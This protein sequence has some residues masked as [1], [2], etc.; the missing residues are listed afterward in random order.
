MPM[1]KHKRLIQKFAL[2]FTQRLPDL[3]QLNLTF[4]LFLFTVPKTNKKKIGERKRDCIPL[5][6]SDCISIGIQMCHECAFAFKCFKQKQNF[7]L[8]TLQISN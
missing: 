5:L 2:E 8:S 7:P 1:L 3:Y 4:V 6:N